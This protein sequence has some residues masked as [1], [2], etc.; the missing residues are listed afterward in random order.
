[1]VLQVTVDGGLQFLD[2]LEHAAA[3]AFAGDLGEQTLDHVEPEGGGGCEV[4]VEAGMLAEP[5]LHRRCLVGA[6]MVGDEM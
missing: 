2:A 6:V 1:M 4:N 3:D 5:P